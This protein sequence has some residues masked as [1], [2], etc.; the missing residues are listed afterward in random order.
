MRLCH[1]MPGCCKSPSVSL[2]ATSLW[3]L[4]FIYEE[5]INQKKI[6][7][8]KISN[9]CHS[10]SME[11]SPLSLC[12]HC[13]PGTAR[14]HCPCL[15][16]RKARAQS[17]ELILHHPVRFFSALHDFDKLIRLLTANCMLKK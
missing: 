14:T 5:K 15:R 16:R 11:P 7:L 13:E 2:D 12:T 1:Q 8:T 9:S 17:Q 3:K 6:L 10:L 4:K